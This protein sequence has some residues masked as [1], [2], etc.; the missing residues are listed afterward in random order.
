MDATVATDV[1]A[2]GP[3]A[4]V[5]N[6][7]LRGLARA[8][9]AWKLPRL[10]Y[11]LAILAVMG[12]ALLLL[13]LYATGATVPG[14]PAS[15]GRWSALA[16][17]AGFG[18]VF[19]I[20]IASVPQLRGGASTL[21]IDAE[22][23]HLIYSRRIRED[24]LW[25]DRRGFILRDLTA[26]ATFA[27]SG[28]EFQLHRPNFWARRTLLTENAFQSILREARRRPVEVA[29]RRNGARRHG[30]SPLTYR[31]RRSIGGL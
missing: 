18:A 31:I 10:V 2:D 5:L 16:M 29:T 19:A 24:I 4:N 23:L 26:S 9:M 17:I 12:S 7:D 3:R 14:G 13:I 15:S 11:L 8:D 21:S 22:G 1:A 28:L 20:G 27:N 25:S 30:F 6:F